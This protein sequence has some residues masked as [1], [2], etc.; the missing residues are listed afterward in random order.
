MSKKYNKINNL[1]RD[2]GG[3]VLPCCRKFN[4]RNKRLAGI[5]CAVVAVAV[6]VATVPMFTSYADRINITDGGDPFTQNNV[7]YTLSGGKLTITGT[8]E[9]ESI[10]FISNGN[11]TSVTIENGITGIGERAFYNCWK[12]ESVT[13]PGSVTS[14]SSQAFQTCIKLT[15]VTIENGV[16]S[17]GASAFSGCDNLTSVTVPSSVTSIGNYAFGGCTGLQTLTFKGTTLTNSAAFPYLSSNQTVRI[18]NGF[19]IASEEV[20]EDNKS[21]YFGQANVEFY[22]PTPTTTTTTE[23]AIV[24]TTTESIVPTTTTAPLETP[25]NEVE[26]RNGS[27][28]VTIVL[29]SLV[30]AGLGIV[31]V[32][33]VA[34]G[35]MKGIL[36]VIKQK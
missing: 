6:M 23:A 30:V 9:I 24:S 27:N 3:F 7:T 17:I 12:M 20:T 21:N 18:P 1:K 35:K 25:D 19:T 4:R 32:I 11:I 29:V 26:P 15:S 16:T 34:T 5:L 33:L 22:D 2:L 10:A 28:L 8:G 31:T 36:T 14:I 13:I